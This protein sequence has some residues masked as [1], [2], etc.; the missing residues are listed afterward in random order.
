[1]NN[2]L[3]DTADAFICYGKSPTDATAVCTIDGC[4]QDSDCPGG[5][6]CERVNAGP[7]VTTTKHTFGKTRS[8]CVPREYCASCQLDHDCPAAADGTQ[9]HCARDSSGNGFCAPQCATN[10]NCP[11]D[12]TCTVQWG[13]CGQMACTTDA[14]CP[15]TTERCSGGV[16]RFGCKKDADCPKSN[17]AVQLCDSTAGVCLAC[18]SD[19][20]CPPANGTYQHCNAG[21][22]TPECSGD[23]DCSTWMGNQRCTP[24]AVCTPRAGSCLGDGGFCAP[25]R[26]DDDCHGGYCLT[27]PY[28]GERFCSHAVK[29]GAT[30]G[31]TGPPPGSCPTR[32]S[33]ANYKVVACTSMADDFAPADQCVAEVTFGTAQGVVQYAPGCWTANR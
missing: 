28:S 22:C 29:T 13:V 4:A 6:W 11:F 10:A 2:P 5:W 19:D 32:P 33:G 15:L 23:S 12:A 24:L 8:V 27:A 16:C 3:C 18:L 21:V 7:N 26:S 17:G 14:D 30:C 31:M 20:D 9:Q 1:V 25:C